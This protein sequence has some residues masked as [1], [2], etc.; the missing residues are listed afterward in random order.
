MVV[1]NSFFCFVQLGVFQMGYDVDCSGSC[2]GSIYFYQRVV[3]GS[4]GVCGSKD[5]V[6]N[7]I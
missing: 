5:G 2:C 7:Y 6:G 1:G 4:L 3:W